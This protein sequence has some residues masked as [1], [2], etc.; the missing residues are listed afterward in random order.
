MKK[1]LILITSLITLLIFSGC[2]DLEI[3]EE[4]PVKEATQGFMTDAAHIESV[5]LSAYY[6]V[7][8][9]EC[10]SRYYHTNIEALADYASSIGSFEYVGRYQGADPTTTSRTDAVWA[11]FY[12]AI[13]FANMI[14]AYA[15][16]AEEASPQEIKELTAEARF[17]RAFCYLHL[18]Q[19]WGAV[20]L[21]TEEELSNS[22]ETNLP[23]VDQDKIFAFAAADLE[24]AATDLPDNQPVV[25]RPHKMTARAVLAEV[26]MH[27]Q[28]WDKARDNA[29]D[30]INSGKYRLVEVS[31]PDDFY[32][33]YHPKLVNS[34]EEIFYLKYREG[35]E[36]GSAFASMLNRGKQYYNGNAYY[37]IHSTFANP[38]YANWS[39]NDLRKAFNIYVV[40]VNGQDLI[41]NKKFIETDAV[42]DS[43]GSDI[44]LYRLAD[45]LLF[46]AEA[47]CRANNGIPTADAMEK[48]NIVHRRAY[49]KRSDVADP[50]VDY[51]LSD[52][53]TEE[54]FMELV[55]TERGYETCYEGKRYNDLKRTG[56]LAEYVLDKKGIVVGEGGYWFAI[57]SQEFLYNKGMDPNKDQNPGY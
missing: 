47:A 54:K 22:G 24:I 51:K 18:A 2:G 40:N 36:Y 35:K 32:K 53:N 45:V 1:K 34:T 13:R 57:P 8:R 4:K 44:P 41:Y 17:I 15:P 16:D 52:Y 10:F 25:G 5:L 11:C 56:K 7:K 49:G 30:V 9:Y 55:L 6:Q 26:Y 50:S 19:L 27:L 42:G 38:F 37:G 31:Q 46:Y 33:L 23:R 12:R 48:L 3:L 43:G 20:P 14:I 28:Q 21:S 29:R 39:D